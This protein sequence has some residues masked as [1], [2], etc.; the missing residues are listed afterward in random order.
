SGAKTQFDKAISLLRRKDYL[1]YLYIGKA[2]TNAPK[3]DYEAALQNLEKAKSIN[4]KD[5]EVFLA[6]GDA[7]HAQMKNSEAYGAYR[8]AFDLDN[9]LL[10]AKVR[11]GVLVKQAKAF[12]ES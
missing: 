1:A 7:Y 10:Q 4:E 2:Y 6:I 12:K 5:A 11:L 3:P 9:N 8:T